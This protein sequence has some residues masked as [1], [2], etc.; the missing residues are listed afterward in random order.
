MIVVCAAGTAAHAESSRR[1]KPHGVA[2]SEAKAKRERPDRSDKRARSDKKARRE[3]LARREKPEKSDPLARQ[4]PQAADQPRA[5][6]KA[7]SKSRAKSRAEAKTDAKTEAKTDAKTEAKQ[8]KAD[9]ELARLTDDPLLARADRIDGS[10]VKGMVAFTFDDGPN[11]ET[12]PLVL[13]AL[14]KYDV[15]ATFFII[16][17]QL[18][19]RLAK[20]NRAVLAKELEGGHVVASH[21]VSH[22]N[23]RT[24]SKPAIVREIDQSVRVLAKEAGRPIGL[25]RAPFGALGKRSRAHLKKRG[26][27]EVKWSIDTI[28]W[29]ERDG[30]QLRQRALATILQQE[31]G[32]VLMHD[33]QEVTARSLAL[34]LD[35]LEAANC[36]RLSGKQEPILPVSLHYWIRDNG[37]PRPV[38]EEVQKRTAAYRAALPARCA[39]RATP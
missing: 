26:L 21:S 25:F 1:A 31:G 5:R 17:R 9:A 20:P 14:Q 10:G 19:G 23:L 7:R 28:D 33:A 2:K 27:T 24:L 22:R 15:P 36:Q 32:V 16:T 4:E 8:R 37:K 6:S 30:E 35:D 39:A 18:V 3:E 12:T 13:E 34:L 29:D 11:A 38:P